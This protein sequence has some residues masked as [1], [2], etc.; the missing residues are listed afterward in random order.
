MNCGKDPSQVF[1]I[2]KGTE[3][4]TMFKIDTGGFVFSCLFDSGA[5]ISYMNMDTVA[6]LG[7]LG[8]LTQSSVTVNMASGQNMGIAGDVRVSF[9]IGR[10][11]SFTHR[12][13]VC[14]NLTRPFILG[15]DFMSQHYMKLGWAPG[16]KRTLGYLD[17]TISVASQDITNEPL[18]LRNSI[19]IPARNCAVVPVHCAQMFSGKV[20]AVT[21]D[22]LKQEFP[23]I[24][25]EP[26]QMDNTEGKS[27]DTTPYM[28]VN[29][30]YHDAVYIK[31]DTPVAY[32]HEDVLCEY[33]EVNEIVESTQGI[34]NLHVITKLL[35]LI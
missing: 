21:C 33:L 35:N 26:M 1:T 2:N 6:V 16:K 19:R 27:C 23:N 28:I 8:R 3:Q 17:E 34:G 14:E 31:K 32:I 24:Y 15:A 9:K 20:M 30:D 4:G 10:K 25:L 7:L 12:F 18:V 13:V 5:E 22:E 29:L 11:Y